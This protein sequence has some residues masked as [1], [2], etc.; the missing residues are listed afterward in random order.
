[1]RFI[2]QNVPPAPKSRRKTSQIQARRG[3]AF[4]VRELRRLAALAKIPER[5]NMNK[6]Q[7]AEALD[8]HYAAARIWIAWAARRRHHQAA[9]VPQPA[10]PEVLNNRDDATG[11]LLDPITLEPLEEPSFA[12]AI[13]DTRHVHYSL[14]TLLQYLSAGKLFRD[15]VTGLPFSD[16]HLREID[17]LAHKHSIVAPSVLMLS[18]S[19]QP[20]LYR[21]HQN[22]VVGLER[23]AGAYIE[24]F[25]QII[26]LEPPFTD[27][28]ANAKR[29][30]ERIHREFL[31]A[32]RQLA[33][34]DPEAADIAIQQWSEFLRGPPTHPSPDPA[35]FLKPILAWMQSIRQPPAARL[36]AL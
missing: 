16:A 31:E 19:A 9:S 1:M 20:A 5:Q 28:I 13:S 26:Q 35:Q 29:F 21:Q 15:P 14:Q 2:F 34:V 10:A 23:I 32:Y 7:L 27:P 18:R 33:V 6:Q 4:N 12:F 30:N 17:A 3:S 22:L 11:S 36:S 24:Q 25:R 8:R